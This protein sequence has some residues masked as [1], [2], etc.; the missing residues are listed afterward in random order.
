LDERA[1]RRLAGAVLL[2]AVRDALGKDVPPTETWHIADAVSFLCSPEREKWEV[3][4]GVEVPKRFI[5][6]L[7]KEAIA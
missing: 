4:A 6:Q 5:N 2:R 7:K 3:L 1:I